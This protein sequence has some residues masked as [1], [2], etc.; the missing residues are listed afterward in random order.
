MFQLYLRGMSCEDIRQLTGF[1]L[2]QVVEAKVRGQWDRRKTEYD[3]S[4]LLDG[5]EAIKRSQL[6]AALLSADMITAAATLNRKRIAKYLMSHDEKDLGDLSIGSLGA[7]Q[8]ALE[9][10]MT[11]TRQLA[12]KG[13]QLAAPA[14][15]PPP[16]PVPIEVQAT[17]GSLSELAAGRKAAWLMRRKR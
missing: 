13:S 6:E 11:A 2:G 14:E 9:I 17:G 7:L 3:A 16:A 1:G 4:L 5:A 12:P 8:K 10:M 15:A